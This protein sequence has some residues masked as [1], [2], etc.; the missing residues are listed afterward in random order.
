[1]PFDEGFLP[2]PRALIAERQLIAV[3]NREPYIHRESKDTQRE[4]SVWS[5]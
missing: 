1:M 4:G 3:S 2:A 5:A